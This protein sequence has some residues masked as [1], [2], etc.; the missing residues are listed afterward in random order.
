M[1]FAHMHAS[2]VCF[3]LLQTNANLQNSNNFFLTLNHIS[4]QTTLGYTILLERSQP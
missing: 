4:L 2:V 3:V 1:G